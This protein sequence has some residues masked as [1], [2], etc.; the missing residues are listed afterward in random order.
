[1]NVAD[2][3]SRRLITVGL[4]ETLTQVQALFSDHRCHHVLVVDRGHLRGV[5][6]DRDVLQRVSCFAGTLAEQRR[7]EETLAVKAHQLMSRQI[8]TATEEMSV[9]DAARILLERGISCLPIVAANGRLA[10]VLTWRDL[11]RAL[12]GFAESVPRGL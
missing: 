6:S 7:D 12:V 5:I 8:V 4:D 2:V 11:L 9:D 3:M 10:G 1:M